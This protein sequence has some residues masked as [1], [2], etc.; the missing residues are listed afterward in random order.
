MFGFGLFQMF[1]LPALFG[2]FILSWFI[3]LRQEKNWLTNVVHGLLLLTLGV[4]CVLVGYGIATSL[5]PSGTETTGPTQLAI[6]I[7]AAGILLGLLPVTLGSMEILRAIRR[8]SLGD[9]RF[10]PFRL[11]QAE[12]PKAHSKNHPTKPHKNQPRPRK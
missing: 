9:E 2:V 7:T 1:C 8:Q 4:V 3:Y 12:P 6:V 5:F 11:R 10:T